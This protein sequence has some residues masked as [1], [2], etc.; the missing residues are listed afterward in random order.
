MTLPED[1]RDALERGT[2]T[3]DQ[4]RQLIELEA[5]ELGLDYEQAVSMVKDG[6]MPASPLGSSIEFLV[7][8]LAA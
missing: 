3:E 8:L 4:I 6:T 7:E 1:L 2:M 5:L